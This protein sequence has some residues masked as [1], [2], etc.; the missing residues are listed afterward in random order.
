[1]RYPVDLTKICKGMKSS[2]VLMC[3]PVE[4]EVSNN[5]V[6][7]RLTRKCILENNPQLKLNIYQKRGQDYTFVE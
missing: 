5:R 7:L 1:M 4:L 3:G 6:S 2:F